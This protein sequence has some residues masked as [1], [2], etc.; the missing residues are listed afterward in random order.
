MRKKLIT[1][2]IL[3]LLISVS[4]SLFGQKVIVQ[5][6][7]ETVSISN[8]LFSIDFNLNTGTYNGVDKLVYKTV[9]A[10]A[11]FDLDAGGYSW[12]QLKYTYR[13]SEQCVSDS[14]G[15]N[16]CSKGTIKIK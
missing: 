6:N 10:G 7:D 9:F 11:R 5:K 15:M 1:S 16:V 4:A 3:L 12:N 2:S 8:A 14:L 13:W